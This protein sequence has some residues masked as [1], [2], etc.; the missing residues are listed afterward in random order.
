MPTRIQRIAR[1]S[2]AVHQ[3]VPV[4]TVGDGVSGA[5]LRFRDLL[6]QRGYRSEIYAELIDP[7]L[8]REARPA[9]HLADEARAEDG[10][11]YHLSIGSPLAADF[12][13]LA[14]QRIVF[15]QNVT[16]AESVNGA[17][18]V[19][20]HHLRW[21]RADLAM[22]ARR[23]SLGLAAS[24]FSAD[25]LRAAGGRRVA[26]VS[27]PPNL[28]RLRPRRAIP[29]ADGLLLFVGRFAPHKRQDVLIR[30]LAA[31]RTTRAPGAKL[32][33][34]GS[35][36]LPEYIRALR[37]FAG[38]LGVGEAVRIDTGLSDRALGDLYAEASVFLCAS[39]HEGFCLPVLEAMSFSV[40]VVAHVAGAVAETVGD[41]GL[42]LA[43]RDPLV[44]AELAWRLMSDVHLRER[45]ITAGLRHLDQ[46][47]DAAISKQLMDALASIGLE[48]ED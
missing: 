16:P 23:A 28:A 7:R 48:P 46:F 15:Y 8:K 44:W 31:L 47:S 27:L 22:L 26:V 38:T 45:F 20:V 12:S 17:S 19:F 32:V 43:D 37:E 35:G 41:G 13:R 36:D 25:E 34:V 3:L 18:P 1:N 4:L 21:G 2:M 40:P 6:R 10:V 11:I 30:V 24:E 42:L 9:A 14:A 33:L 5:V 39:D 29:S